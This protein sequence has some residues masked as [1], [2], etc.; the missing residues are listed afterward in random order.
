VSQTPTLRECL[1]AG[2]LGAVAAGAFSG[3]LATA[4]VSSAPTVSPA[5]AASHVP[6]GRFATPVASIAASPTR[7]GPLGRRVQPP[8]RW[9]ATRSASCPRM[10]PS[11]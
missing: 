4:L 6:A 2:L 5:L 8:A 10:S 11:E 7:G 3:A 1:R 9:A